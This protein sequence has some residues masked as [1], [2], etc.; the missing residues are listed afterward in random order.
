MGFYLSN[1]ESYD[2][3]KSWSKIEKSFIELDKDGLVKNTSV[4]SADSLKNR[5]DEIIDEYHIQK[6]EKVEQAITIVKSYAAL[7]QNGGKDSKYAIIRVYFTYTDT[8]ENTASK[9]LYFYFYRTAGNRFLSEW[10]LFKI[11]TEN[12]VNINEEGE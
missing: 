8:N 4:T 6:V 11:E 12:R 5:F 9:F 10:S 2:I 7:E 1:K 3:E